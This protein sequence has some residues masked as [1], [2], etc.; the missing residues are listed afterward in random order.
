MHYGDDVVHELD[1]VATEFIAGRFRASIAVFAA[2]ID[3]SIQLR[4]GNCYG[5]RISSA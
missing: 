4:Y 3:D 5:A 1:V 2:F